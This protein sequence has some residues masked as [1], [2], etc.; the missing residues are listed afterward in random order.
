MVFVTVCNGFCGDL[1][2]GC[3]GNGGGNGHM[4]IEYLSNAL[5]IFCGGVGGSDSHG[6]HVLGTSHSA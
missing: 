4:F 1:V 6:S 2:I 3:D 5:L